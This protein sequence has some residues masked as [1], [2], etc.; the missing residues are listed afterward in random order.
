MLVV[1][2][3]FFQHSLDSLHVLVQLFEILGVTGL[4]LFQNLK[5]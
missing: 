2:F 4:C 1:N 5:D 3:M